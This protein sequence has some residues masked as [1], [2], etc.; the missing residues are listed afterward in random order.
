MNRFLFIFIPLLVLYSSSS[1]AQ[2]ALSSL[3]DSKT[4]QYTISNSSGFSIK[5]NGTLDYNG[6][7]N[8]FRKPVKSIPFTEMQVNQTKY[9]P[10][11]DHIESTI[12]GEKKHNTLSNELEEAQIHSNK[13]S[14]RTIL[15]YTTTIPSVTS[16][17]L[18]ESFETREVVDSQS[19]SIFPSAFP[20]SF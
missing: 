9:R 20:S 6:A 3:K 12:V 17:K 11:D 5:N 18:R 1:K 4:L 14:G 13:N 19:L 10:S 16:I 8:T 15:S 2:S 7:L